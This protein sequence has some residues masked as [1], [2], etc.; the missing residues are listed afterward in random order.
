MKE[1][2]HIWRARN[3]RLAVPA[4]AVS[5]TGD[6]MA[7]V[8]LLLRVHDSGAGPYAVTALL[9]CFSLPVV[10]TMGLAGEVADRVDPRVVFGL[11]HGAQV[12]ALV[13]LALTDGLVATYGLVLVLQTGFAFS[14]P[15]WSSV[16]SRAVGDDH[17]GRLVSVQQA[18]AAV[19]SPLGAGLGGLL[20]ELHGDRVVFLVDAATT[21]TLLVAGVLVRSRS[22]PHLSS[23]VSV[24][25]SPGSSVAPAGAR[26]VRHAGA[27]VPRAGLAVVRR[28]RVV[29]VLVLALLPFV[30]T[31][32]SMN[33]VEVF[34]AR[35][36]LGASQAEFGF[37]QTMTGVGAFAGAVAAG[38]FG[39]DVVRL[40]A[41][42]VCL[43]MMSL[44]QVGQ[45]LAPGITWLYGWGAVL[46]L[47]NA[48]SNAC[49]FAVI[50]RGIPGRE[51]GKA[52]A[53]INGSARTCTM[54]A[55]VLG[56]LAASTL[57]PRLSY[58][59]AGALGVLVAVWAGL[60]LHRA[61]ALTTSTPAPTS[62]DRAATTARVDETSAG[63]RS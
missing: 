49:L 52:M 63:V 42:V 57:G 38:W 36:A 10:V 55:L 61:G 22:E 14:N 56:G 26:W 60:A 33:A 20:V 46:G 28:N 45:G 25:S 7:M 51:R 59:V 6:A 21:L 1:T 19:A 12:A 9:V 13:G 47:A 30:V 34:L 40:R 35:D 15:L 37:W 5:I 16:L 11:G 43:A 62:T 4:A 54:L 53:F 58:V 23:D 18:L 27:L 32:E 24:D 44:A 29:W 2:L 50:V 41:I 3:V 8:A 39:R 17:V 48:V 31:L